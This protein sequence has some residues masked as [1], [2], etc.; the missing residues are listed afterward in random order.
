MADLILI[1]DDHEIL[2]RGVRSLLSSRP[3]WEICGEAADGIDAI[4]KARILKPSLVLMDISMPRMD[5]LEA[6]RV[7]RRE[8]PD[9][10]VIILS[11][12]DPEVAH[13]QSLEVGAAAFVSKS[14]L[15]ENLLPA[16]AAVIENNKEGAPAPK[17]ETSA[18][19]SLWWLAGG[20]QLA[21]LI[22]EYN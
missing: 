17:T 20:G 4:E 15:A 22:R 13:R 3:D 6:T 9:S 21:R 2:R 1:V 7:L 16:I 19:S 11:Q 5:G 14:A 10:K 18:P 8:L 12:N